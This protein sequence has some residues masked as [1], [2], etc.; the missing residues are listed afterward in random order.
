MRLSPLDLTMAFGII[1]LGNNQTRAAGKNLIFWVRVSCQNIYLASS[2]LD[3]E[4]PALMECA[5]LSRIRT[6][7]PFIFRSLCDGGGVALVPN[8]QLMAAP[9]VLQ[10]C[11]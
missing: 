7:G 10:I 8:R 4:K 1:L 9:A 3:L 6:D 2:V 5:P 11:R